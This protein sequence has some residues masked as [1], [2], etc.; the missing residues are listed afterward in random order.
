LAA[1][2]RM[3]TKSK[4][5]LAKYCICWT[6]IFLVFSFKRANA[7]RNSI[8]GLGIEV[9]AIVAA[10][11]P[12]SLSFSALPSA[13]ASGYYRDRDHGVDAIVR[14]LVESLTSSEDG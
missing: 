5:Q 9:K 12:D 4:P 8:A 14:V 3:P 10:G 6:Y 2:D 11:A 13:E 1:Y 7:Y